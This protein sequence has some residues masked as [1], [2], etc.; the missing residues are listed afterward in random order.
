MPKSI[1][2]V[3][4][5]PAISAAIAERF[6]AAGF[7]VGLVARNEQRLAAGV[8][9]LEEKGIRAAA[10]VA[11]A[12]DPSAIRGAIQQARAALGPIAILQWNAASVGPGDL[13]TAPS[14]EVRSLFDVSIVGLLAAV[15]E[16]LPD[17]KAVGD[18]A[19]LITNGGL[20]ELRPSVDELAVKLGSMGLALANAAKHK[21]VGLLATRLKGHGV[22]VGEVM[23]AGLVKGS[24]SDR[25]HATLAASS[26]AQRFWELYQAR[27]EVRSRID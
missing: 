19:V 17:L 22:Y 7:A 13:L 11:D 4:Y 27:R 6:G 1:L 21:L 5:G 10:F 2:V 3:G 25:G 8:K 24:A 23:V 20:G 12:G 14:D 18:G 26:V 15:D 9:A 16:A